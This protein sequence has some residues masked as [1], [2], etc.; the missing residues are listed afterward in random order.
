M[1]I[2]FLDLPNFFLQNAETLSQKLAFDAMLRGSLVKNDLLKAIFPV[3]HS[4]SFL[5]SNFTFE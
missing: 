1:S 2:I 3:I 4:E 5:A